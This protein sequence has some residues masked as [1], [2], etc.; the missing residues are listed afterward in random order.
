[1]TNEAGIATNNSI[2]YAS[3]ARQ[4]NLRPDS[5]NGTTTTVTPS[6]SSN[7]S[8]SHV[9]L[10]QSAADGKQSRTLTIDVDSPL[11]QLCLHVREQGL[12]QTDLKGLLQRAQN[13]AKSSSNVKEV[14]VVKE[15]AKLL[16]NVAVQANRGSVT[17]AIQCK[18]FL[19]DAGV[20]TES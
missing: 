4:L 10:T 7:Q 20:G 6:S 16:V 8:S 1:M 19:V 9:S 11:G 17:K 12:E 3:N 5:T 14:L 18:P 2:T 15:K 13:G